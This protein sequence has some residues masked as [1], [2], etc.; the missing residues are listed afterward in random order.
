MKLHYANILLFSL[1]LNILV[2][3]SSSNVNDQSNY[4]NITHHKP[5]IKSAKIQTTRLLCEC[6]L[7]TSIYN[8]DTEMKNVMEIFNKQTEQRFEEYNERMN[9]NRQKCKE[10]CNKDIQKIILKDKIEKELKQNLDALHADITTKDIPTYVFEKSLS[11]KLEKTCLK[12]TYGLGSNVPLLGLINGVGIYATAQSA[13]MKVFISETIDGLK[14][15]G[16][17]SNLFGD[18]IADLVTP[19]F[20]GKPMHLVTTILSAKEKLCACPGMQK[21]ILCH[22]L[23]SVTEQSLPRRIATTAS[24]AYYS[25]GEKFVELTNSGAIFSNP[26]VISTIVLLCIALM[27][28]IIY[29]ILRY[30]RK[31]RMK[32]KFQYIK[33]L[34]E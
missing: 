16:G 9:K 17:M 4:V 3:S 21:Q 24:D 15:I 11:G 25:A 12:C 18:K 6:D 30:R 26:I 29:L 1:P 2:A 8:N 14:G 34:K 22:G 7:Y 13:A 23:E 20:Y 19:S 10:Q 31:S 5:N 33:L 27:L 28:L 32:K